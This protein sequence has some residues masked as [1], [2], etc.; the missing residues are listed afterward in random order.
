MH[1]CSA[2]NGY[3]CIQTQAGRYCSYCCVWFSFN[4][5]WLSVLIFI[6]RMI[7]SSVGLESSAIRWSYETDQKQ[8]LG[9][10]QAAHLYLLGMSVHSNSRRVWGRKR[11]G[12]RKE[13]CVCVWL[14][15]WE[16]CLET[17]GLPDWH[18][19]TTSFQVPQINQGE[20][21]LA[22]SPKACRKLDIV[23]III[24]LFIFLNWQFSGPNPPIQLSPE[25][26]SCQKMLWNYN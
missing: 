7:H 17:Q 20:S 3:K 14:C 5:L 9:Q 2:T 26:S 13:M 25:E 16:G 4:T 12:G 15:V 24:S 6:R 18:K 8:Q 11:E 23:L 10:C 1:M 21:L 22:T 19:H